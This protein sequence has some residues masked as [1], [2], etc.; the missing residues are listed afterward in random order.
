MTNRSIALMAALAFFAASD[1]L[2]KDPPPAFLPQLEKELYVKTHRARVRLGTMVKFRKADR[3]VYRRVDT[4]IQPTGEVA[5]LCT[6]G[7]FGADGSPLISVGLLFNKTFYVSPQEVGG[8]PAGT[9][10]RVREITVEKDRLEVALDT[11]GAAP[12][13]KIKL[14][15]GA[16][17][18][19]N[20][21]FDSVMAVLAR[22]LEVE[23]YEARRQLL[24][25]FASINTKLGETRR[26]YASAQGSAT[27]RL[28]AAEGHR[29][30]LTEAERISQA[31]AS[32]GS[33]PRDASGYPEERAAVERAIAS[34]QEGAR[35]EKLTEIGRSLQEV[36]QEIDGLL[37]QVRSGSLAQREQALQACETSV[38]RESAL[39]A[40]R[41]QMGQPQSETERTQE[42]QDRKAVEAARRQ[43]ETQ[44]AAAGRAEQLARLEA[45]YSTLSPRLAEARQ[46]YAQ[47]FGTPGQA[48]EARRLL[49][50]LEQA[51]QNRASASRAGSAAAAAEASTMTKEIQRMRVAV[52]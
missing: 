12:Y 43:L 35:A 39:F 19:Q 38:T 46:A 16:Q 51:Q 37:P 20:G 21:T 10:V 18:A 30:A 36:R 15:L 8:L 40:E 49:R 26:A 1:V 2:A 28:Q 50:L 25:Q 4:E 11:M 9:P 7:D 17:Y 29:A 48:D 6:K 13:A 45:E 52:R 34:L 24:D 44:R 27:A 22:A 42:A 41:G 47:A 32:S 31:L 33:A 14:M 3:T 5:Y 23:T